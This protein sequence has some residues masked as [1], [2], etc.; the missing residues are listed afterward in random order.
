MSNTPINRKTVRE[1]IGAGLAASL[2]SAQAVYSHAKADFGGQSPV[3]RIS[4]ESSERPGLTRQGI[5][6]IF[7]YTVEVWVL[8]TDRDGWTEQDAEDTLD[9]LEKEIISWMVNN[10]NTD[11]WTSLTYDGQ[12]T[13]IAAI[14][15]GD[16]WL[17]ERIPIRAEV[18]G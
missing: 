15:G 4:S 17:I 11:M 10:H 14:D 8:L 3:V 1:A 9:T 12:S 2:T 18:Y 5:R 16:T 7:R 6:S 13:V